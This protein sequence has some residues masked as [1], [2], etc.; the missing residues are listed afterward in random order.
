[1]EIGQ[2]I[3]L[4]LKIINLFT[5]RFEFD[6]FPLQFILHNGSISVWYFSVCTN[7]LS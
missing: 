6:P 4:R 7:A 2:K 3:P 5:I 1:M